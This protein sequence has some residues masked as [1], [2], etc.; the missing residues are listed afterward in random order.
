[1]LLI[2]NNRFRIL[3]EST[4]GYSFMNSDDV[5]LFQQA[6]QL[7]NAGQKQAAYDQLCAIRTHGNDYD[8]D[9]LLWISFASPYQSEAQ[10]ALE[11]AAR[12]A[13]DHPGL[14]GAR[15]YLRQQ[16]QRKEYPQ[17]SYVQ[18]QYP[19]RSYVQQQYP[20][21]SYLQYPQQSYV[22]YSQ[23]QYGLRPYAQVY[24]PL[25]PVIPA[26]HCPYCR[27][28]APPLIKSRVSTA[29]WVV[30]V[31]LFIFTFFFC[32]IGLLIREDYRVCSYCGAQLG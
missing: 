1:M 30:F 24:V 8:P 19:Q 7:A 32:W 16:W 18:Q 23:Q 13:P 28:Y 26:L 29:G 6:K 12:V 3:E 17:R 15:A 21:Q 9:L 4:K 20:Q 10:E 31:V 11:T 2:D 25:V 22:Q 27:S 14:P 5:A